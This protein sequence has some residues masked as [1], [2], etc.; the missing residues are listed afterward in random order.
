MTFC[1]LNCRQS[2]SCWGESEMGFSICF[3]HMYSISCM[4]SQLFDNRI[5]IIGNYDE[6]PHLFVSSVKGCFCHFWLFLPQPLLRGT[7]IE[8]DQCDQALHSTK[9][10]LHP[11]WQSCCVTST[12]SSQLVQWR[13]WVCFGKR[14]FTWTHHWP[15]C[16]NDL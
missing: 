11:T 8:S 15:S 2:F 7:W 3:V 5:N 10:L 14:M 9:P 12:S 4:L 6:A 13:A 1:H 16:Q